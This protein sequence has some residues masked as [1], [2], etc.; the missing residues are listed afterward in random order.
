MYCRAFRPLRPQIPVVE[1]LPGV[2]QNFQDHVSLWGLT[3]THDPGYGLTFKE[4]MGPATLIDY[5]WNR[6]G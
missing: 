2:G 3:W 4:V 6:R 1:D 5:F